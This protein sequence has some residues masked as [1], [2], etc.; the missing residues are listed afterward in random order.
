[1]WKD[2]FPKDW[3]EIVHVD[4][5]TGGKHVADVKMPT[6]L[7]VEIQHSPISQQELQSRENFYGDM[8]WIVDAR[9]LSGYFTLGTSRDLATCD[10]MTYH[11]QWI[12]KSTL[13]KRWS[14]ARKPVYFDG[15]SHIPR[16]L[17]PGLKIPSSKHTLWRLF[18][19]NVNDNL[20]FIAP[21]PSDWIAKAALNG[22]PL[23]LMQC[24]EKD[25]WRYRRELK[26]VSC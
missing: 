1:M 24:E 15:D 9:D 3:Q 4:Q 14:W 12:S 2:C 17:T 5:L 16:K 22:G 6:G 23:P 10:P 26:E 21:V 25:A 19:F 11:F 13:L 18:D 20:G 8:I 7:V